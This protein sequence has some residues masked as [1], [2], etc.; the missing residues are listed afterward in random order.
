MAQGARAERGSPAE[1]QA[2]QCSQEG[3]AEG[4]L[5]ARGS[6]AGVRPHALSLGAG[7]LPSSCLGWAAEGTNK[8]WNDR[9]LMCFLPALLSFPLLHLLFRISSV[10]VSA[11]RNQTFLRGPHMQT[12]LKCE[13]WMQVP[14]SSQFLPLLA[15][16]S[17]HHCCL[18]VWHWEPICHWDSPRGYVASTPAWRRGWG[19]AVQIPPACFS[20]W[21]F[22]GLLSLYSY[23]EGGKEVFRRE[24]FLSLKVEGEG[25]LSFWGY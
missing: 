5:G 18:A 4:A 24:P 1:S 23:T 12:V 22:P 21:L 19:E 16:F 6:V 14:V 13:H 3:R 7:P 2:Q 11:I 20:S 10:L 25:M 9:V 15:M 8:L 17:S